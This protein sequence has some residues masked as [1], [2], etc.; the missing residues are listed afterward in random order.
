MQ[1]SSFLAEDKNDINKGKKNNPGYK[2]VK[3]NEIEHW[4]KQGSDTK[5]FPERRQFTRFR[6]DYLDTEQ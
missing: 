3:E 5:Q 6:R 1:A 4:K 2:T